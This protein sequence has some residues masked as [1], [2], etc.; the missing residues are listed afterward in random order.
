MNVCWYSYHA[1]IL[2]VGWSID[3]I[4]L[5]VIIRYIADIACKEPLKSPTKMVDLADHWFL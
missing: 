5:N 3:T 1:S 2:V 4:M